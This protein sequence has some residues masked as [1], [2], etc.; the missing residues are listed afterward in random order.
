MYLDTS[1]VQA[2]L[3]QMFTDRNATYVTAPMAEAVAQSVSGPLLNLEAPP[4]PSYPPV[5]Y[6]LQQQQQQHSVISVPMAT[7]AP[8]INVSRRSSAQE[9]GPIAPPVGQPATMK[10]TVAPAD[11]AVPQRCALELKLSIR[12]KGVIELHALNNFYPSAVMTEL[13][14]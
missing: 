13:L 9:H 5:D 3:L 8:G 7:A 6:L 4:Q 14:R 11:T 2:S 1:C 12:S 10:P